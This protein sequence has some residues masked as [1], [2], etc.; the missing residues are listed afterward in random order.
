MNFANKLRL[1]FWDNTYPISKG[2]QAEVSRDRPAHFCA[3]ADYKEA[4]Q[5]ICCILDMNDSW[6]VLNFSLAQSFISSISF[7]GY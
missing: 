7:E 2:H 1:V 5:M 4:G 6:R 3:Q